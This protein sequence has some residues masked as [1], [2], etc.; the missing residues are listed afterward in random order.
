VLVREFGGKQ[1][2]VTIRER[3]VLYAGK[4]YRS[5]TG[6]AR[7][8]TGTPWNGFKFFALTSEEKK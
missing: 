4:S 5:L 6:V 3:D 8:I 2:E 7:A 1:H